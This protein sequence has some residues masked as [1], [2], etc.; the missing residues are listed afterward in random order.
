MDYN[1]HSHK[2]YWRMCRQ[3]V[4]P[5]DCQQLASLILTPTQKL[6][7][8]D[9]FVEYCEIKAVENLGRQQGDPLLGVGMDHYTG[10]G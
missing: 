9:K 3:L 6:S 5:Y 10:A 7:W 2:C 1:L 4:T 8:R